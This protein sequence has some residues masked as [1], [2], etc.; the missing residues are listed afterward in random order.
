M[1]ARPATRRAPTDDRRRA[2]RAGPR[3]QPARRGPTIDWDVRTG[4]RLRVQPVRRRRLDGRPAAPRT[5]PGWP[6]RRRPCA[7]ETGDGARPV[8][9]RDCAS[10]SRGSP[11]TTRRSPTRASFMSCSTPR[12]DRT[13]L[14]TIIGDVLR[15]ADT[16][17]RPNGPIDGRSEAIAAMAERAS[18]PPRPSSRP[19]VTAVY[20]DPPARSSGRR[21]R[22]CTAWLDAV[23]RDRAAG[24]AMIR[25]R[26]RVARRRPRLARHARSS[27][28]GRP[29]ASAGCP[30][31]ASGA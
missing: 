28:S 11:S 26:L 16:R 13:V 25:A 21:A 17:D 1:A 3:L 22:C 2:A 14:R 12:D 7:G 19:H 10:C 8:R 30:S 23:H 29:A 31:P 24:R 9:P 6:R 15:D 5:G 20:S 4:L 27:S 18:S